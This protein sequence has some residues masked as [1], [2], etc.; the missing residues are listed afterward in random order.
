M[1]NSSQSQNTLDKIFEQ[2]KAK[3]CLKQKVY[4]NIVE[5]FRV[6]KK[7]ASGVA[8][9]L[10]SKMH[11]F[12]KSVIVA[13]YDIN[14]FEFHLKFG[15]D[16]LVF[17]LKSNIVSFP[18]EYPIMQSAYMKEEEKRKYFGSILVYNFMADTMKYNRHEDSG[19][20][21]SR[22]VVNIDNHFY[23]EGVRQLDFLF[24]E[25][26]Q[27]IVSVEWL[28]LFVE[29][30]ILTALETDLVGIKY[31]DLIKL[32]NYGKINQSL[33]LGTGQKIGF[34]MTNGTDILK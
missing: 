28:K 18:P 21:M 26:E 30:L 13:L 19:Y 33:Q 22:I 1:E 16:L 29:K 2:L 8:D 23:I 34:Q 32:T 25:I 14:E 17:V 9:L 5:V 31:G 15:G 27:N 11:N 7:E 4:K 6:L 24:T 3:A 10:S 12:D 20:L